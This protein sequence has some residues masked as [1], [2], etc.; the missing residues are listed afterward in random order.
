MGELMFRKIQYGKEGTRG[1]AVPATAMWPGIVSVPADRKPKYPEEVL[2]LR[3]RSQR[4]VIHQ[5]LADG[6]TLSMEDGI[7]QKL[8]ILGLVTLKGGVSGVE[9]TVDQADYLWDVTPSLTAA[10]APDTMTLEYGD[11]TQAYEIEYVMGKS[12]KFSGKIGADEPV[13]VEAGLFGKQITPTTFT[14]AL[15]PTNGEAMI[16]NLAKLFID[17]TW[18][19]LGSTQKT[20]LLREFSV[21]ILTGNHPKFYANG[22]KLM[23]GYGEGFLDCL[24]ALTFEGNAAADGYFDGFQA[25]TNYAIQLLIEGTQIGTGE[26]HT[27]ELDFFG[28]FEEAIPLAS[29]QDGNNLHTLMFHTFSDGQATP[30][31]FAMK[32]ITNQNTV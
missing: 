30:H 17:S 12:L 18:A 3:S 10:N 28:D 9:Q 11:D 27:L 26:K 4:S 23:S 7:F 20:D 16:A 1:T 15:T 13:K 19:T 2:G 6:L 32:V 25:G 14:A 8:P 24:V 31:Q 29:E 21:E 22:S 5:I